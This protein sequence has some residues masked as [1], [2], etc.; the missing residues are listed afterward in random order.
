M[1]R[2]D[3]WQHSVDEEIQK[4][5]TESRKSNADLDFTSSNQQTA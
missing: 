1:V 2:P 4:I 5:V 3:H